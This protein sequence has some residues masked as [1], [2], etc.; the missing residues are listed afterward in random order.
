MSSKTEKKGKGEQIEEPKAPSKPLTGFLQ[1]RMSVFKK[2][3]A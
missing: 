3:Q 2:V 1:Y